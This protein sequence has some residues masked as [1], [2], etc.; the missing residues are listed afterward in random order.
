[1]RPNPRLT[2]LALTT[3]A[4]AA[5]CVV[6]SCWNRGHRERAAGMAS[7]QKAARTIPRE[8]LQSSDRAEFHWGGVTHPLA[9][10]HDGGELVLIS[11]AR[12]LDHPGLRFRRLSQQGP[13]AWETPREAPRTARLDIGWWGF[14]LDAWLWEHRFPRGDLILNPAALNSIRP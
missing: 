12:P 5:A 14:D 2:L 10:P 13:M 9:L 11:A 7:A 3:L 6:V 1:M 8:A 4:T